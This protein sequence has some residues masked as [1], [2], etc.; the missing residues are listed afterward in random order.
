MNRIL[1]DKVPVDQLEYI[2]YKALKKIEDELIETLTAFIKIE[3]KDKVSF[4]N[5]NIKL[6]PQKSNETV[7]YI[8]LENDSKFIFSGP[9]N[10]ELP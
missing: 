5:F 2:Y 3:V 8:Y 1:T 9:I 7:I 6:D 10:W 4:V